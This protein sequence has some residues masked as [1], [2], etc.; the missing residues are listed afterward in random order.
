MKIRKWHF[1]KLIIIFTWSS[2]L[3]I[4]LYSIAI[5]DKTRAVLGILVSIGLFVIPIILSVIMWIWLSG[6]EKK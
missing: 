3:E 2:V 6:K 5:S 4:I 1:G